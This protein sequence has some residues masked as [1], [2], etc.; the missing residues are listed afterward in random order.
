MIGRGG[1][2]PLTA[3]DASLSAPAPERESSPVSAPARAVGGVRTPHTA[4]LCEVCGAVV[5]GRRAGRVCSPRCR[6][7]RWRQ[8]RTEATAAELARLHTENATLRQRVADLERLVGQL[9]VP[10]LADDDADPLTR[11]APAL[12]TG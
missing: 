4:R 3:L 11:S 12:G 5:T 8:T 9:K 10:P 1:G 6:I 2:T 7:A